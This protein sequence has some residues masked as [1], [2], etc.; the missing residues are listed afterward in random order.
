M[1]SLV[2][3]S[4]FFKRLKPIR[5]PFKSR[6]LIMKEEDEEKKDLLQSPATNSKSSAQMF[7]EQKKF[8]ARQGHG[9]AAERANHIHDIRDGKKAKIV[10]GD[11]KKNGPDRNVNG[12]NIQTKFCKSSADTVRS[13]LNPD[14]SLRYMDGSNPMA[15]EVPKDQYNDVVSKLEQKI[16]NGEIKD[17]K[18]PKVA[19]RIIKKSSITYT[20]SRN[21]AKFATVDGLVYD[22]EQATVEITN[23]K[24]EIGIGALVVFA[25]S[26]WNGDYFGD[27]LKNSCSAAAK[28]G[29]VIGVRSVVLSELSKTPLDSTIKKFVGS[30]IPIGKS[31]AVRAEFTS[32]V[33]TLAILSVPDFIQFVSGQMPFSQLCKNVTI[34]ASGI[35]GGAVG[36]SAGAAIAGAALGSFLPG[37]GTV[38][39]GF[40]GGII[41]SLFGSS[42]ASSIL[43]DS[44]TTEDNRAEKILHETL[45][46]LSQDFMLTQDDAELMMIEFKRVDRSNYLLEIDS[47][48]DNQIRANVCKTFVPIMQAILASHEHLRLPST[49]EYNNFLKN[50]KVKKNP[51]YESYGFMKSE[52]QSSENIIKEKEESLRIKEKQFHKTQPNEEKINFWLNKAFIIFALVGLVFWFFS[53][54]DISKLFLIPFYLLAIAQILSVLDLSTLPKR[55]EDWTL[56]DNVCFYSTFAKIIPA[57]LI[58]CWVPIGLACWFFDTISSE[59]CWIIPMYIS[60]GIAAAFLLKPLVYIIHWIKMK[61]IKIEIAKANKNIE[62]YKG[63][64]DNLLSRIHANT[65]KFEAQYEPYELADA[66]KFYA[67]YY[68][69]HDEDV[70]QNKNNSLYNE[71]EDAINSLASAM[72]KL[73]LSDMQFRV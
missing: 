6:G 60:M 35:A 72:D 64:I 25:H 18:D 3:S 38:L 67:D 29:I 33:V 40:A 51:K 53:G 16:A 70:V 43:E 47:I 12:R 39:G 11:N 68:A 36:A 31:S 21:I 55:T 49:R 5:L 54:N 32:S 20:Q 14:G 4:L 69:E 17:I 57:C 27:A 22:V 58:V 13:M 23:A 45:G 65:T 50:G 73:G 66:K 7:A 34:T 44:Y 26:M 37:V 9:Y 1:L 28:S 56:L 41:G 30:K 59:L 46:I 63:K 62:K 10:G 19:K 52:I 8:N 15:V 2:M 24:Y 42:A 61:K 71:H 48:D